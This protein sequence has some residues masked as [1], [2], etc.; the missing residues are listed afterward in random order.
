M[1]VKFIVRPVV[2]FYCTVKLHIY[3]NMYYVAML[4]NICLVY[5]ITD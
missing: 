2:F 4:R 3:S 5:K 1:S